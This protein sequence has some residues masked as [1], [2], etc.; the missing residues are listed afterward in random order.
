MLQ[1]QALG[2]ITTINLRGAEMAG[3]LDMWHGIEGAACP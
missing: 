2:E 3:T 1:G